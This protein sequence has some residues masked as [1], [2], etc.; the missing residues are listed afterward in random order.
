MWAYGVAC[1]EEAMAI[2]YI[3]IKRDCILM[4]GVFAEELPLAA[5]ENFQVVLHHQAQLDWLLSAG[6]PKNL[7][8]KVWV[9]VNTGMNRIGFFPEEIYNVLQPL[10][11]V[12][13][14]RSLWVSSRIWP[15]PMNQKSPQMRSK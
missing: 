5:Q 4:Q 3:G 15:W 12:L 11:P 10:Q 1:L 9:K 13:G 7:K 2:R 8:L 6:L 14:L